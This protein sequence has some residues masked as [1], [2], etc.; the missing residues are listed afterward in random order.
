M[1]GTTDHP[2]LF[3]ALKTPR[4]PA[5]PQGSPSNRRDGGHE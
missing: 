5:D 1:H 2:G 3:V 4:S